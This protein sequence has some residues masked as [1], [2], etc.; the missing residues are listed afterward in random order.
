MIPYADPASDWDVHCANREGTK[1]QQQQCVRDVICAVYDVFQMEPDEIDGIQWQNVRDAMTKLL[2]TGFTF[3]L[4]LV[5]P[6]FGQS[7]LVDRVDLIPGYTYTVYWEDLWGGGDFSYRDA[8]IR[9]EVFHGYAKWVVVENSASNDLEVFVGTQTVPATVGTEG[10]HFFDLESD[11]EAP[12]LDLGLI[13]NGQTMFF[14]EWWE[15]EDEIRH[16]VVVR[17][18]E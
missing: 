7:Q 6:V 9:V 3:L 17:E 2:Q 11:S 12:V 14:P 1:K 8:V 4:L 15:N 18:G 13:V 16:A 10:Y 5:F